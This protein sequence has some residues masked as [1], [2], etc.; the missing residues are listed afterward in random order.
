M[1]TISLK[2]GRFL[3]YA[4]YGDPQGKPV[5]FFHGTPGSRFFIHPM[6]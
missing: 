3:S 2:D 4:E 5:F 6:R 1:S